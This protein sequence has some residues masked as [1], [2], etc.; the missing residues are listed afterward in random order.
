MAIGFV[1]VVGSE[2]RIIDYVEDSEKGLPYY[3]K[4][5]QEKN[6][7]YGK[8]FAPHDIQVRELTTGASRLE[9]AKNLGINFSVVPNRSVAD[10]IDAVRNMLARTWFD[11]TNCEKLFNALSQYRKEWNDKLGVYHDTPLH[12]WT[13]H[14]SDMVRY[15]AIIVDQLSNEY[16]VS[17]TITNK[18]QTNVHSLI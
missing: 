12:D 2:V 18:K 10:G 4:L 16:E 13:S 5:L 8:H 1:Q 7:N 6:Y 15:L 14:G 17:T 3:I 9:T 11:K